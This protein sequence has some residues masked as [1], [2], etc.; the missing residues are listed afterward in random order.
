MKAVLLI[1]LLLGVSQKSTA[2]QNIFFD[3]FQSGRFDNAWTPRPGDTTGVVQVAENYQNIPAANTGSYGVVMGKSTNGSYTRNTLDL[4][5]DL[6]GHEQVELS[7]W[8]KDREDEDDNVDGIFF[9]DNGGANFKQVF[10][11]E[12]SKWNDNLYGQFPP[13]DVDALAKDSSLALTN[14]FV[15]RF[16]QYDERTFATA[17]PDGFFLDDVVVRPTTISHAKLPFVDGFENEILG[18][19]WRWANANYPSSTSNPGTV[20]P[21]GLVEVR[22]DVQGVIAAHDGTFGV[23]MGRRVNGP[24]TTNALDLHL[25]LSRQT[26]VD[27]SFWIKD[28][29]DNDH[30]QDGIFFSD[31]GGLTF[32]PARV[33]AFEPSKWNDNFYGKLPPIDVDA[34]AKDRGLKLTDKF[35]IRF[36]Q[37]G[38]RTFAT[39]FPDGIFVD[40]IE[41][42][43]SQH[44]FASLPF[45]DGFESGVLGDSWKW[46][47]ATFPS[48]T[49]VVGTV[50]PGGWVEVLQNIQNTAAAHTGSFGVAMGR[51]ANGA[52]T[53]NALDLC[54][55]LS[56]HDQV[57]LSF[58]IK[59]YEDETQPQDG[60]YFSNDGGVTFAPGA[61][62]QFDPARWPDNQ[63]Q[64]F[65]L[66][67]DQLAKGKG[68]TLTNQFVI[69]FQQYDERTFATAFPD[70]LFLDDISV[71]SIVTAVEERNQSAD[72]PEKFSVSQNYPNPFNPSTQI[73]FALPSAQKV[74]LKVFDL[75]GKE[76]ATLLH[77]EHKATG[78][79]ALTFDLRNLPSGVYFYRLTAGDYVATRKML[80]MR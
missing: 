67:V 7:F 69:R 33:Y 20:L 38:E 2:R 46:A 11:F 47:D 31:D 80:L 77:N 8:I 56:G 37:Y 42:E 55:D 9:S 35:V 12:P 26:E 54:L 13:I 34:R 28:Q 6:S 15:I 65:T 21:G 60:I 36:Q 5:L 24:L 16:Q 14:Q 68:L 43:P 79:H 50:L 10:E 39:S 63:Y 3:S 71:T 44:K 74:T 29:E 61:V 66:D 23:A 40:D 53:T 17:F 41:V 72:L 32:T 48:S 30:P 52:L 25:D 76:V 78:I 27:L 22:R 19:A 49:T 57:E 64:K 73:T 58:W 70:G 4:R 59:D 1:A 18:N 45:T 62:F 51:R 75:S